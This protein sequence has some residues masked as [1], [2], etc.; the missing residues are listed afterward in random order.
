MRGLHVSVIAL[1]WAAAPP[2][3]LPIPTPDKSPWE[4]TFVEVE[5]L[6]GLPPLATAP[7]DT[8][9]L[10]VMHRPWSAIAP[11]PF[12]RVF[13]VDGA[14]RAEFFVFGGPSYQRNGLAVDRPNTRCS[15]PG[16][17]AM[18]VS[19]IDLSEQ[20]DWDVVLHCRMELLRALG[21]A[22]TRC[23]CRRALAQDVE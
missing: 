12:L 15:P 23:R 22:V 3:Q 9:E 10:R 20:R 21:T 1:V 8:Q 4:M 18:C 11:V 7:R 13:R 5:E 16:R 19:R 14:L 17:R 2:L 6:A